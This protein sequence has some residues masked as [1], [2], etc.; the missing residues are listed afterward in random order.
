MLLEGLGVV[1]YGSVDRESG[2]GH[3]VD[4]V[5]LVYN[6]PEIPSPDLFGFLLTLFISFPSSFPSSG[7]DFIFFPFLAVVRSC[8]LMNSENLILPLLEIFQESVFPF[9]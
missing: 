6:F 3:E 7:D 4:R 2:D 9:S 5:F 1:K 8:G